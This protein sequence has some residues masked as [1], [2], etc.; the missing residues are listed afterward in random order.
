MFR[1]VRFCFFKCD[2]Y[3]I[4]HWLKHSC[5]IRLLKKWTWGLFLV[6]HDSFIISRERKCDGF[7]FNM[8]DHE[9]F[10]LKKFSIVCIYVTI[11]QPPQRDL[12]V[13]CPYLFIEVSKFEQSYVNILGWP[14]KEIGNGHEKN[15]VR[16]CTSESKTRPP[17]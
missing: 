3:N 8:C 17:K 2:S 15:S 9:K 11:D 4:T 14:K 5:C 6:I 1:T 7:D 13:N 10:P 12:A 16:P